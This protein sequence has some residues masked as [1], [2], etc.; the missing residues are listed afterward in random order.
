MK[1]ENIRPADFQNIA[2]PAPDHRRS[3][4]LFNSLTNSMTSCGLP[5]FF[6]LVG[7]TVEANTWSFK[8]TILF[9]SFVFSLVKKLFHYN[10]VI[11]LTIRVSTSYSL[12]VIL[13]THE[14][15]SRTLQTKYNYELL[16]NK[17]CIWYRVPFLKFFKNKYQLLVSP[18][19]LLELIS[20]V[21]YLYE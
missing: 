17:L 21:I 5:V 6:E 20:I 1:A 12:K 14:F 18:Y 13:S 9:L 19:I 10:F 8:C 3:F 2:F 11:S 15:A 4:A 16:R 7:K